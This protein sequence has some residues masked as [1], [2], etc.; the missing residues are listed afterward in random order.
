MPSVATLPSFTPGCTR[1]THH[2][3]KDLFER[4]QMLLTEIADRAKVRAF[5]AHDSE[6]GQIAFTGQG[7]LTARKYAHAIGIEQEADHHRRIERG[8]TAG[9][10]FI[11]GIEA[12]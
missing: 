8:G 4:L 6:K 10:G 11:G 3:H 9:F 7:D 5:R 1:Q 2:V 12:A